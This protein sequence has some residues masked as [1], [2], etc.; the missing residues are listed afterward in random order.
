MNFRPVII[1][2]FSYLKDVL[3]IALFATLV[4]F[5]Y[6]VSKFHAILLVVLNLT[7]YVTS[8]SIRLIGRDYLNEFYTKI[9]E[10]K[11]GKER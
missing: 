5:V 11:N 9:S 4:H 6:T 10:E 1:V 7:Y 2:A 3:L 8:Y